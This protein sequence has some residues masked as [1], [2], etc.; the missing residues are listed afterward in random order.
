VAT[1]NADVLQGTLDMLILKALSLEP[2]HG[3]GISQ[4]IQQISRDVLQ[5]NQG[6]LYPAL[7]RLERRAWI[8]ADW[9]TSENNRRAKYYRLT[10]LGRKHLA[11]ERASWQRFMIAVERVMQTT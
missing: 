5:I 7:H 1:T 9:G 11:E 6:S 4:R 2:M 3:W 8:E 10:S